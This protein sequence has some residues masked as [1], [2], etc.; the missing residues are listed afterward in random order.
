M[1]N[2]IPAEFSQFNE[3]RN[4]KEKTMLPPLRNKMR[5]LLLAL[6][7]GLGLGL[8][9][10][11]LAQ[12]STPTPTP[13]STSKLAAQ[14]SL[15]AAD[16]AKMDATFLNKV[17]DTTTAEV[18]VNF[19][20][21]ANMP[22]IAPV[23]SKAAKQSYINTLKSRI[24]T[25]RNQFLAKYLTN[26]IQVSSVLALSPSVLI[27]TKN[28]QALV[29]LLKDPNVL[30]VRENA[31]LA[32]EPPPPTI[33]KQIT[34][35]IAAKAINEMALYDAETMV[36]ARSAYARGMYGANTAVAVIDDGVADYT[37]PLFDVNNV[38][39]GCAKPGATNCRVAAALQVAN[40][41][42]VQGNERPVTTPVKGPHATAVASV[43]ARHAPSSAIIS[44]GLSY[45]DMQVGQPKSSGVWGIGKGLDWV[46]ENAG[47]YN[48]VAANLS[49]ASANA[50]GQPAFFKCN[51]DSPNS[52][53][54]QQIETLRD[55]GVLTVISA[56]NNY[57]VN[58]EGSNLFTCHKDVVSVGQVTFDSDQIMNKQAEIWKKQINPKMTRT[59]ATTLFAPGGQV[60]DPALGKFPII[61]NYT[62]RVI[63]AN[64]AIS[65]YTYSPTGCVGGTSCAAPMV[66]AAVALLRGT[67]G[68]PNESFNQTRARLTS[69]ST[70][71]SDPAPEGTGGTFPLLDLKA[72]IAKTFTSAPGTP[73]DVTSPTVQV[74]LS[75]ALLAPGETTRVTLLFSEVIKDFDR[76]DIAAPGYISGLYTGDGGKTWSFSYTPPST[77]LSGSEVSVSVSEGSYT[78]LAGNVGKFGQAIAKIK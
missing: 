40:D 77:A 47:K 36:E 25:A 24:S 62:F 71:L 42:D 1:R 34:G 2:H 9:S 3:H 38:P 60:L 31:K 30:A 28:R 73:G 76:S 68:F 35:K 57:T 21:P 46:S 39:G 58:G 6:G 50:L 23:S 55:L 49:Q 72:A 15:T 22:I 64:G 52:P 65:E 12:T 44:L 8:G 10:M 18:I 17:F 45:M 56:G 4:R 33:V 59:K 11:A 26:Q 70:M 69:S 75:S 27:R 37:Q 32:V 16:K 74:S 5:A 54:N 29:Q 20:P 48:I 13:A 78:D 7:L 41:K 51:Y 63:D 61:G 14:T 66:T 43:I 67:N 19:K 53:F